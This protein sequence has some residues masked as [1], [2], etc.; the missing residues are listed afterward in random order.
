MSLR[1]FHLVF[2]TFATLL[3]AGVAVWSFGFAPRDS[4]WMVTALGVMMVLATI[5]LPVYGIRFY[6][7]AKDLIL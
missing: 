1:G 3:C 5:A 6:R 2:I 4:G 7:K